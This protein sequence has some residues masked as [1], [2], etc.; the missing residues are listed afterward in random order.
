M[1]NYRVTN[2]ADPRAELHRLE[3]Q[4][5]VIDAQEYEAFRALGMPDSGVVLD[6]GCGPAHFARRL[7][8][9]MPALSIIGVDMDDIC[10]RTAKRYI[11]AVKAD[12]RSLPLPTRT[13]DFA[14][15][16]LALRHI[17]R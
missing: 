14:Y 7:S 10:L 12:A 16:R 13:C 3:R 9:R 5:E 4:A 1:T 6:I 15:A 8:S 17:P 2:Y 11:S